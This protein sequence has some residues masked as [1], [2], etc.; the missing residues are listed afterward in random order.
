MDLSAKILEVIEKE[1]SN[2]HRNYI[3][4]SS[5]GHPCQR[6]LWYAYHNAPAKEDPPTLKISFEIGR[7]L[8]S[9]ILDVIEKTGVGVIRPNEFNHQLL[10]RDNEIPE[11]QGHMDALIC[12]DNETYVLEIKTAKS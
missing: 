9:M 8:E 12:A 6:Y 4:C 5:I 11:F 2:Q 1:S 3:G 10:C 7:R